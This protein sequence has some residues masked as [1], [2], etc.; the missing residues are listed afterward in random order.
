MSWLRQPVDG[1][2]A[3]GYYNTSMSLVVVNSLMGNY[4]HS[5]PADESEVS[6]HLCDHQFKTAVDVLVYNDRRLYRQEDD[7][8]DGV[9][10][11]EQRND[12]GAPL[13]ERAPEPCVI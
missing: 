9:P 8:P 3:V 1:C 6:E 13:R 2:P 5:R 11:D 10:Q 12:R 7:R 4:L